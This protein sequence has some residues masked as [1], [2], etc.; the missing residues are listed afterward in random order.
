MP[1][2]VSILNLFILNHFNSLV[3]RENEA[4]EQIDKL[5]RAN[6]LSSEHESR[7]R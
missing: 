3:M 7:I 5:I 2:Q 6:T 4:N 1:Y